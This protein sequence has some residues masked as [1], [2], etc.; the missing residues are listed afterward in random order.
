M[1]K[2][3]KYLMSLALFL[4]IGFTVFYL[5]PTNTK[6]RVLTS[7]AG[8][9]PE[10]LEEKAKSFVLTPEEKRLSVIKKLENKIA[11][12]KKLSSKES[13]VEAVE[14]SE[15][16]I[17]ELKAKNEEASLTNTVTAKLIEKLIKDKKSAKEDSTCLN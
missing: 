15:K 1:I 12:I 9:M 8:I 10:K 2:I 11:G 4:A 7:L 5:L 14:E 3:F 17:R 13:I 16:L 6:E